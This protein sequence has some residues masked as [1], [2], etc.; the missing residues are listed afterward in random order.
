MKQTIKAITV[1]SKKALYNGIH[2]ANNFGLEIIL[3]NGDTYNL[4]I[5]D[6]DSIEN[7]GNA[8][9]N[10][11]LRVKTDDL[12]NNKSVREHLIRNGE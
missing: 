10:L 8:L 3:E 1:S 9:I 4:L 12:F 11:G 5:K 2:P 6:Y 7:L